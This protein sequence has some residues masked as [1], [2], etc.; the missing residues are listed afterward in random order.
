MIFLF[1]AWMFEFHHGVLT[2]YRQ[3]D[4]RKSSQNHEKNLLEERVFQF[5]ANCFG[6]Y[7]RSVHV[8]IFTSDWWFA[9]EWI[10][11][12]WRIVLFC[13]S[14][15]VFRCCQNLL[16]WFWRIGV[17]LLTYGVILRRVKGTR[18]CQNWFFIWKGGDGE[19]VENSEKWRDLTCEHSNHSMS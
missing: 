16:A 7:H 5:F 2:T 12:F 4:R 17:G 11:R 13:F 18:V 15:L 19:A 14:L 10:A 8:Q 3:T 1:E 6:A 9:C